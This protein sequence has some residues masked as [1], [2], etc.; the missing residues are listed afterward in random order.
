M[1]VHTVKG[2]PDSN[3]SPG[4]LI[5]EAKRVGLDGVCLSEHGGGWDKWDFKSFAEQ[6]PELLLIRAL[7]VD[8]EFGHVGVVGLDG[9]V[10]GIHRIDTLRK[11]VDDCGGFMIS[12]HPF[13][14]FFEKP[15]LNKSLLFKY[16]VGLEEAIEHRVFEVTDAIE[17]VNGAC[18]LRE[19][20]FAL[21]AAAALGK[22]CTGGSERAFDTRPGKRRDGLRRRDSRSG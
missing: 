21:Q 5:A 15:P 4:E 3:L 19:N 12:V 20:D 17:A 6:H 2:G 1:H 22:P 18:T 13:R 16:P 7:E 8:T 14:R 9:Y 10:S 11:V